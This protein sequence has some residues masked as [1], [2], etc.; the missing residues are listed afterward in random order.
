MDTETNKGTNK[1]GRIWSKLPFVFFLAAAVILVG[2]L[3]V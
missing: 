3:S 1:L 2:T